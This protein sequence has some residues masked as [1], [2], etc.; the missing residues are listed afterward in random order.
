MN[1]VI[2]ASEAIGEKEGVIHVATSRVTVSQGS[3][4]NNAAN[5]PSGEYVQLEVSDTGPGM[6]EEGRAK[7]FD[8]FF[9]TK[10]AGR[11]LG[12]AIVQRIVRDQGGAL[13]VVSTPG[14]GATFRVLLSCASK[15]GLGTRST[16]TSSAGEQ[17]NAATG[18]MLLVEDEEVLR[19]AVS[20][21]LRKRGFSVLEA[22]DGSEAMDLIRARAD[23]ID[24]V[25]LDVTLPGISTR[26]ILEEA[27]RIRPGLK[28]ILTSAYGKETISSFL[29]L[30]VE[31]FIRKPFQLAEL[32]DELQNALSA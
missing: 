19:L 9:S 16:L 13:D 2:N 30:R 5:L 23:D 3:R 28:V 24:V 22:C 21:A 8:P 18:T 14:H 25:L 15:K 12:L 26:E 1:L 31:R 20:K 11:G 32:V 10:F 17:S 4:L 7:I 27:A 29:G 6:T